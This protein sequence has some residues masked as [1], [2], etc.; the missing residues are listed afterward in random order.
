MNP[1][2][3]TALVLLGAI[4]LIITILVFVHDRDKKRDSKNSSGAE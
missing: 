2:L 3:I 4:F 1:T